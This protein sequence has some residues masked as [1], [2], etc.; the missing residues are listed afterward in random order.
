MG[1]TLADWAGSTFLFSREVMIHDFSVTIPK[2]YKDVY[3]NSF[4]PDTTR[5]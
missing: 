5:L 4:F 1:F 3:D 2:Y